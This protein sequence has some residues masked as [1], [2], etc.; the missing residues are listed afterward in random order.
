MCASVPSAGVP[1]GTE[2]Q[3]TQKGNHTHT[4]LLRDNSFNHCST[5]PPMMSNSFLFHNYSAFDP[6]A[7]EIVLYHKLNYISFPV[8]NIHLDVSLVFH[9]FL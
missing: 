3:N 2:Q 9:S 1:A 6:H 4:C 5:I 7:G 8:N